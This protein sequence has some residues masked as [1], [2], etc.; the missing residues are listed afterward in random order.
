MTF[1]LEGLSIK[2]LFERYGNGKGGLL[3]HDWYLE[4]KFYTETQPSGE[5]EFNF[6]TTEVATKVTKT[7]TEQ[8]LTK[9]NGYSTSHPALI[10]EAIF[11]HYEDTGEKLLPN[12]F[13]RTS[14][15]YK[16]KGDHVIVGYF[17]DAGLDVTYCSDGCM[18]SGISYTDTKK[19]AEL[20][21]NIK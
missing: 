6:D 18:A 5:Y 3:Q 17:T 9:R 7:Y 8:V 10:C 21:P 16:D 20:T 11:K 15:E 4:E 12:K 19:V 13:F 1:K 2:D 14:V